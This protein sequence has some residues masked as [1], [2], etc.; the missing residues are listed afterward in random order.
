MSNGKTPVLLVI[1]FSGQNFPSALYTLQQWGPYVNDKKSKYKT[2]IGIATSQKRSDPLI[3]KDIA[4]KGIT[5]ETALKVIKEYC[6]AP[7]FV[8]WDRC[9]DDAVNKVLAENGIGS[10]PVFPDFNYGSIVNKG[11][12]LANA[13]SCQYLVRVDPGTR[14]PSHR[15]D[16]VMEKHVDFIE[17]QLRLGQSVVVSRG[18]E[19]RIAVRDFYS[20]TEHL[21]DHH[22]L[23]EEMTGVPLY[24]QVTGG[25]MFTSPIPG[26]PAVPFEKV[27]NGGLVLVWASDDGFYQLMANTKESKKIGGV[28]VPRFVAVGKE[29][30]SFEYYKGVAGMVFLSSLRRESNKDKVT[31]KDICKATEDVDKFVNQLKPLL[32]AKKCQN[33]DEREFEEKRG[34]RLDW[35]R[36]FVRAEIAED[37]FL[38]QIANGWENY[39][40]LEGLAAYH[41]AAYEGT[42]PSYSG[43]IAKNHFKAG[44]EH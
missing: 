39:R 21:L 15:F 41:H 16:T 27:E 11:L 18:Y 30:M 9:V 34:K 2:I 36:D 17:S 42:S 24:A 1:D 29:K 4:E 23:V 14:P 26:H 43:L 31:D 7:D 35:L 10:K 37:E 44:H 5:V 19:G 3:K 12:L 25:A 6:A 33:N 38:R 13:M 20:Q 28:D 8:V 32:D 40:A 22:D